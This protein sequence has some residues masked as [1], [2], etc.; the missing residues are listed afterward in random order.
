M[1]TGGAIRNE[2]WATQER[3]LAVGSAEWSD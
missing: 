3:L 2:E 1:K